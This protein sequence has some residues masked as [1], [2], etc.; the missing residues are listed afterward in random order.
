MVLSIPEPMP[1]RRTFDKSERNRSFDTMRQLLSSSATFDRRC[2][3]S[4][5]S[6]SGAFKQ[7]GNLVGV[8]ASPRRRLLQDIGQRS[9]LFQKHIVNSIFV[10]NLQRLL[11]LSCADVIIESAV[12]YE[13]IRPPVGEGLQIASIPL[14]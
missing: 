12:I 5:C 6:W 3:R 11:Y 13:N 9:F 8:N 4:R 10:Q 14:H 2:R 7:A 1:F